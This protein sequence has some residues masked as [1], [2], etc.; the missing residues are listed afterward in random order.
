[1]IKQ[2]EEFTN[3]LKLLTTKID[4]MNYYKKYIMKYIKKSNNNN[5][6]NI[7]VILFLI[8]LSPLN[9]LTSKPSISLYTL[10]SILSSHN[11]K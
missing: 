7:F 2:T 6:Y 1:M 5:F 8:L 4:E 10:L 3:I 11:G 9:I